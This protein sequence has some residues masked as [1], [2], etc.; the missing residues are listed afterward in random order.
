MDIRGFTLIEVIIVIAIIGILMAISIPSY[1]E[2]QT[3]AAIEKQTREL[4]ALIISARLTAMQ[5]KQPGTLLLGPKQYIYRV[6]DSGDYQA[7]TVSKEVNNV[8]LP[9]EIRKGTSLALLDVTSD[10]IEF[11]TSGFTNDWMTLVVTPVKYGGGDNCIVVH[12][13]RT[14]I[15]RMDNASKCVTR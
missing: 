12:T 7:S 11:D 5:T 1:H 14:N 10:K 4:H 13:A 3:K 15:G 9:Y 6:Y 2:M 8:K